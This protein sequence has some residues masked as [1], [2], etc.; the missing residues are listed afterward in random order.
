MHFVGMLAFRMNGMEMAYDVPLMLL[1]VAVAIAAS[2]LAL[3][4]VS[5]PWC[6][7]VR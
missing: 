1:S 3:F 7:S 6:K 2:A 4:V 5:R